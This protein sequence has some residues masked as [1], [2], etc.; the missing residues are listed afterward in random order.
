MRWLE[1]HYESQYG[2]TSRL[3]SFDTD[4]RDG[5]HIAAV[6]Q[7]YVGSNANSLFVGM[8][9]HCILEDDFIANSQKLFLALQEVNLITPFSAKDFSHPSG[10]D[11]LLLVLHLYNT[12]PHFIPRGGPVIFQCVLGSECTRNLELQN[13]T[14]K[15][16]SYWV[17]Y[18][19]APDF[20]LDGE[21]SFRIEPKQTY[22]YKVRFVSRLGQS[23]TGRI[24]FMNKLDGNATASTLVFELKS[25]IVGR[26][27]EQT[28][29]VTG[30]LYDTQD[31]SIQIQNKFMNSEY[32]TFLI[33]IVHLPLK[34]KIVTNEKSSS[35]LRQKKVP[36]A[37]NTSNE[38]FPCVFCRIESIRLKR[39]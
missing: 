32:G 2:S 4:L 27:S 10:K 12:L 8:K 34:D 19:G 36:V 39:G 3:L 35:S 11:M 15:S 29:Q 22:Q 37:K 28:H 13:P 21:D 6:V 9:Q 1:V 24:T 33:Q 25:E 30:P 14:S 38:I 7:A 26:I 20:I 16:I 5:W 18:E 17:R 31:F 23:V